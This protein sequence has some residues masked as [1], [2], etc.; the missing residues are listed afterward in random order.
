MLANAPKH[1]KNSLLIPSDWFCKDFWKPTAHGAL[2]PSVQLENREL[3][4][5]DFG[6]EVKVEG[7]HS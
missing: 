3:S 5:S 1:C 7:G 4:P 6:I 2:L